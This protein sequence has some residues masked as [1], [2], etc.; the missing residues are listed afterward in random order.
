MPLY[1]SM[2]LGAGETTI[3]RV[4]ARDPRELDG[5]AH[6]GSLEDMAE[7]THQSIRNIDDRRGEPTQPLAERDARTRSQERVIAR[8]Q[9]VVGDG[10]TSG[11]SGNGTTSRSFPYEVAP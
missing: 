11:E 3:Q 8:V 1:Y 6:P 7:I 4:R 2:S 10:T 5:R 9:L